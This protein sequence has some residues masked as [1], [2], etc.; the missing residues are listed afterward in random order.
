MPTSQSLIAD[1]FPSTRRGFAMSVLG[2]G[3]PVAGLFAPVVVAAITALW[4]WRAAFLVAVLPGVVL[5]VL[6][7]WIVPEPRGPAAASTVER[8]RFSADLK[9]FLRNRTFCFLV[10]GAALD[11]IA[12]VG[13]MAFLISFLL[14][15]HHFDL[16][17]AAWIAA[18]LALGGI[19]G[20][21]LGGFVADRTAGR[22]ARSY[23][24]VPAAGAALAAVFKATGLL[25]DDWTTAYVLLLL[26]FVASSLKLGP[27]FA[28]VQNET[29]PERRATASA[30]FMFGATTLGTGLG[31]LLVG[32]L[33]DLLAAATFSGGDFHQAC[34]G[35]RASAGAAA[36]L[37]AAGAA[38]RAHGLRV[39]MAL[40]ALIYVGAAACFVLAAW[41]RGRTR[42][43]A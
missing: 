17:G 26:G 33:S 35:G 7:R 25:A 27:T 1:L 43:K 16:N 23:L 5:I 42:K 4:G 34:P 11:G 15:T 40:A 37:T 14:R 6:V 32:T 2:A 19:A 3:V 28:A 31:P 38:A 24:L 10:S 21:L 30:L 12:S 20:T 9:W 18:M 8:S 39:A 29:T 36:G 41:H 22:T 13:I